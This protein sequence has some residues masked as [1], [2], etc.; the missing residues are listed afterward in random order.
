[1]AGARNEMM[2]ADEFVA[3]QKIIVEIRF[4]LPEHIDWHGHPI[5]KPVGFAAPLIRLDFR[6]RHLIF[7]QVA[8]V[9]GVGSAAVQGQKARY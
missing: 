5:G 4:E 3:D 1:V 9:A 2:L 8:G 7:Q 6:N